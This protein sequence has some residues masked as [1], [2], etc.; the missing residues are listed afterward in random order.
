MR[1]INS[2]TCKLLIL[3]PRLLSHKD[4]INDADHLPGLFKMECGDDLPLFFFLPSVILLWSGS[5]KC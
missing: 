2:L 5:A 4:L 1:L 3:S